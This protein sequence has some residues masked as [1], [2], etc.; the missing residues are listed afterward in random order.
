VADPD[1]QRLYRQ[2]AGD[3]RRRIQSGDPK[4]G[5]R[6]P[7]HKAL[8]ARYETSTETI[9]RALEVL[10]DEGLVGSRSTLGTYVLNRDAGARASGDDRY[11]ELEKRVDELECLVADTRAAVGLEQVQ[12]D[13]SHQEA[14]G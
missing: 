2:I 13:D 11:A 7:S 10:A 4:P 8:A 6:L 9:R 12:S 1:S 5:E 3:L 14:R